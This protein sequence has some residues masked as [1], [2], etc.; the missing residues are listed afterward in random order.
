M[1][2]ILHIGIGNFHRA[3]QAIYTDLA[4]QHAGTDWRII[5][6]SLR[7]TRMRD[8][9]A[10][11][12]FGYT[13]AVNDADGAQYR[14]IDVHDSVLAG[15]TDADD[16]IATIAAPD[17]STVTLTITENGYALTPGGALDLA[18]DGIARDVAG[19]TP[20][21][22]I[23]FLAR[24]LAA[25]AA[26]TDAPINVISCDN[27]PSNGSKLAAAVAQFA[28]AAGLS[29]Q[30]YLDSKVA[31]PNTMVDRIV[32]ATSSDFIETVRADTGRSDA[33]PVA[34]EA[35][36][37][38]VV[39]DCL[40]APYPDWQAVGVQFVPDVAPFELR[41]LRMLNGAHS[42]LAYQGLRSG[43]T[44]VHEAIADPNLRAAASQL[45]AE[46]ASTLPM[47]SAADADQYANS[48]VMRFENASLAHRL[49]QIAM[50][51]S[52]KLPIRILTTIKAAASAPAAASV[53]PA[54][55]E[56]VIDKAARKD[57]LA[58]PNAD[59][60]LAIANA[61]GPR[62]KRIDALIQALPDP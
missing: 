25:R 48:L 14:W 50:D 26:A 20:C 59:A 38:W 58:D 41:K 55:A 57:A 31:F 36:T 40:H 6:A 61:G 60:L 7:S 13:L 24:G 32:P 4:N 52:L 62:S 5:G 44:Y 28:Q 45:M 35:F 8:L 15:A 16:I 56:F 19:T 9:L 53:L 29:L 34:T 43:H 21:T 39:E 10:P 46:A 12:G 30:S 18:D 47:A 37:E 42:L 17:V 22:A 33:C 23:G 3:H 2:R 49:D 11:Q 1:P 51:G 54:W 27:L